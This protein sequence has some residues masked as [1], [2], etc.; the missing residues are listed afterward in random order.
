MAYRLRL[1]RQLNTIFTE[2][3]ADI[4]SHEDGV[5]YIRADLSACRVVAY[6]GIC[7]RNDREYLCGALPMNMQITR[8]EALTNLWGNVNSALSE[9]GREQE[10]AYFRLYFLALVQHGFAK[11]VPG[12]DLRFYLSEIAPN[13]NHS[14][15]LKDKLDAAIMSFGTLALLHKLERTGASTLLGDAQPEQPSLPTP[16]DIVTQFLLCSKGYPNRVMEICRGIIAHLFRA[17]DIRAFIFDQPLLVIVPVYSQ[18]FVDHA[19]DAMADLC[20]A[21]RDLFSEGELA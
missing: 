12:F 18:E 17:L 3:L 13:P 15:P 14:N 1:T 5:F 16:R 4:F 19:M 8:S 10:L 9:Q 2:W 6:N 21:L 7:Q 20:F 11:M